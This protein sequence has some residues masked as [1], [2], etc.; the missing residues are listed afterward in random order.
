MKK[1]KIEVFHIH[2]KSSFSRL[3]DQLIY[4]I[5]ENVTF[6]QIEKSILSEI[7]EYREIISRNLD[8]PDY[9][10]V[11]THAIHRDLELLIEL[12]DHFE[13]IDNDPPNSEFSLDLK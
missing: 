2:G 11:F 12:K 10:S 7:N 8:N 4:K 3:S 5:M 1:K 9:S 6:K 13:W